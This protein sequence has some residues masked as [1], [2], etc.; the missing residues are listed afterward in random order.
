MS[1]KKRKSSFLKSQ[2]NVSRLLK[3]KAV[4]KTVSCLE[5]QSDFHCSQCGRCC[6]N[7]LVSV[8]KAQYDRIAQALQEGQLVVS[9]VTAENS[10]ARNEI[11]PGFG[12]TQAYAHFLFGPQGCAFLEREG[13]HTACAV[14]RQLRPDA[15]PIICQVYPRVCILQPRRVCL[16][17]SNCC[18]TARQ[19]LWREDLPDAGVAI[20]ENPPAF[21]PTVN[22]AGHDTVEQKPPFLR[23]Q[24]PLTWEA[25]GRWERFCLERM[26]DE[27]LT[28]ENALIHILTAA[29]K[30]RGWAGTGPA[31]IRLIE[32]L[33]QTEAEVDPGQLS[34]Q[35][36]RL[37]NGLLLCRDLYELLFQSL[38]LEGTSRLPE[39]I[40]TFQEAYG[41]ASGDAQN[42]A[43]SRLTEDYDRFVRPFWSQWERAVRRYLASKLFANYYAH[44]GHGL[45][46]GLYVVVL[47][48]ATLRLHATLLTRIA[49]RPLDVPLLDEAFA[50][51]DLYWFSMVARD[52]LAHGLTQIETAPLMELLGPVHV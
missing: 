27:R 23:P 14:Q 22:Y 39:L 4:P 40:Q 35:I 38:S 21:S 13:D 18:P 8:E 47:I 20:V 6:Q 36:E 28:P 32:S 43:L 19:K 34:Q 2:K 25:Y 49:Q 51:T 24:T 26:A 45:R 17:L 33:V 11:P 30:I 1:S 50:L 5:F 52:V 31:P 15:L 41:S 12:S 7:W 29:E 44:E 9:G 46:T 42:G 37:P 48:L 16:T 10:M 3:S